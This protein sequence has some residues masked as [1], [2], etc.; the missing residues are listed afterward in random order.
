MILIDNNLKDLAAGREKIR[1]AELDLPHKYRGPLL[2]AFARR[3]RAFEVARDKYDLQMTAVLP[4][5]TI[6]FAVCLIILVL[7]LFSEEIL[8][9]LAGP[10]LPYSDVV[11]IV[12]GLIGGIGLVA[13]AGTRFWL[14]VFS[15]PKPPVSP[16]KADIFYPLMPL[17]R[18]RLRGQLPANLPYAGAIGEYNLIWELEHLGDDST[19][20]LYRLQQ[21]YGDDLDVT[22]VGPKG[23]WVFEVKYWAGTV[24]LD[25]GKWIQEKQFYGSGHVLQTE[26]RVI[27]QPPGEQWRRMADDVVETIRRH[28]RGVV[29]DAPS[30]IKIKGGLVSTYPGAILQI[31][32]SK[33]IEH[34]D[35]A[36]WLN[37]WNSAPIIPGLDE[38][39]VLQLLDALLDRHHDI[40]SDRPFS[41]ADCAAQLVQEQEA[42]VNAW[43]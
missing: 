27:E 30:I 32:N 31:P 43:L 40:K 24:F 10:N 6:A 35:I 3:R 13:T 42:K 5:L 2:A 12:L 39:K 37:A 36:Y 38:G 28:A 29:F 8:P 21:R 22:L 20:I 25:N 23:I 15:R 11:G 33:G 41:M 7:A 19:C 4:K 34:G 14:Q 9:P 26:R 1:K 17:W 16:Q 18:G